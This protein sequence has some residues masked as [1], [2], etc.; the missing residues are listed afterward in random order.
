MRWPY[1]L[2]AWL[3]MYQAVYCIFSKNGDHLLYSGLAFIICHLGIER[4]EK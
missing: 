4:G 1:K 3:L 2:M